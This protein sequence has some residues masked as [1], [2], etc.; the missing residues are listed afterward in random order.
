MMT[1]MKSLLVPGL[2]SK[3]CCCFLKGMVVDHCDL[4]SGEDYC[5]RMVDLLEL[6]KVERWKL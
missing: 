6:R 5:Y 3:D 4:G 1:G 2:R